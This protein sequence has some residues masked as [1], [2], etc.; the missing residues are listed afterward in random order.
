MEKVPKLLDVGIVL[1]DIDGT[2]YDPTKDTLSS[3]TFQAINNLQ[4]KGVSVIPVTARPLAFMRQFSERYDLAF[5][6]MVVDGGATVVE[7]NRIVWSDWLTE[8]VTT[9]VIRSIGRYS[10]ILCCDSESYPYG[11]GEIEVLM[12]QGYVAPEPIP[13]VFSVFEIYNEPIIVGQL[14]KIS[15]IQHTAVM[16]YENTNL[17][18]TQINSLDVNKK[19][20]AK[21][22]IQLA[23]RDGLIVA[24]GDGANDLPLFELADRCIAM[25]NAPQALKNL[26]N[27]VTNV[28]ENDGFSKGLESIGVL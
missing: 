8:D 15:D 19:T 4:L 6:T 16:P 25:G 1:A 27:Y 7:D 24:V 18:C 5:S 2:I 28:V 21:I 14:S 9:S 22:A 23:A 17:L 13:S 12:E 11:K 3:K 20:G 26:A 10:S